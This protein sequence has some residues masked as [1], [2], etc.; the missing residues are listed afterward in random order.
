MLLFS[1]END[2]NYF[3]PLDEALNLVLEDDRPLK[4]INTTENISAA[5]IRLQ[6]FNDKFLYPGDDMN[7]DVMQKYHGRMAE[8][9]EKH[10]NT[11]NCIC[12][13]A[14]VFSYSSMWL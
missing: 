11:I 10:K 14:T 1:S 9:Y 7:S 6:E 4:I 13:F 8:R 3:A 2:E 5:I 12:F